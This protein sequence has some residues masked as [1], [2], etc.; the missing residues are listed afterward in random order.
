M[1]QV[2]F[3][4]EKS[5][6]LQNQKMIGLKGRVKGHLLYPST[7]EQFMSDPN[8]ILVLIIRI[9]LSLVVCHFLPLSLS[10][11]FYSTTFVSLIVLITAG[12][13]SSNKT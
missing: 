8:V 7:S 6:I 5:L 12:E 2:S 11:K 13:M 4:S 1:P 10:C 9:L 3:I